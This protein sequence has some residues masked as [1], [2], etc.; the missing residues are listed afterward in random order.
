MTLTV[1]E[2]AQALNARHWGDG[3][4]TVLGAAE[5]GQAAAG[6]ISLATSP[7]YAARV[8][9][10]GMAILAEGMDPEAL[11][12]SAAIFVQRPR[13]AMAALTRAFDDGPDIAPGVHPTA[14][15]DPSAVIPADAAIGP[16][17]V[18]GAR[19]RLGMAARI[20]AHVTI[21]RDT[22]IGDDA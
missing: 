17:A 4:L 7:I 16:F 9:R 15:I 21:G 1:A 14:V 20:A 6:Q 12:L 2:L 3:S 10:G 19:V 11:G 22:V 18:I 13:L 5:A 8:A